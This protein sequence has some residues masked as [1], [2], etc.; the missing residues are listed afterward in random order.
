[1]KA[2][3]LIVRLLAG[4]LAFFAALPASSIGS[5]GWIEHMYNSDDDLPNNAPPPPTLYGTDT[6]FSIVIYYLSSQPIG[7][8]VNIDFSIGC[9][10]I[11]SGRNMAGFL[12]SESDE[13]PQDDNMRKWN[14]NHS[15][16]GEVLVKFKIDNEADFSTRMHVFNEGILF[17]IEKKD[18][19]RQWL[20]KFSFRD[21]MKIVILNQGEE[22]FANFDIGYFEK[23]VSELYMRCEPDS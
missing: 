3:P 6:P 9:T 14:I 5:T 8:D 23:W 12:I 1:M 2:Q 21:K 7:G 20:S 11:G 16:P 10:K 19:F 13:E 18:S 4:I 15:E 22:Y 17:F